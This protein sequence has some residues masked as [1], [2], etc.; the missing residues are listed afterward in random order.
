MGAENVGV[1][2]AENPL[3]GQ[4]EVVVNE[5]S[6]LILEATRENRANRVQ[7]S[8]DFL[9]SSVALDV[10]F[11]GLDNELADSAVLAR[12]SREDLLGRAA[13]TELRAD[14]G[15][16]LLLEQKLNQSLAFLSNEVVALLLE[17]AREKVANGGNKVDNLS[18]SGVAFKE[19]LGVVGNKLAHSAGL[20]GLSG[21]GQGRT[22]A[23]EHGKNNEGSSHLKC[24]VL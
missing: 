21:L 14:D 22:E 11:S 13:Q 20:A 15:G 19:V 10:T 12:L 9:Q 18:F 6:A 3:D 24:V 23:Q 8:L 1:L 2:V 7:E 17:S 5:V 4:F 16:G